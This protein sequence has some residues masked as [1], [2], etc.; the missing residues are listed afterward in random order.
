[1]FNKTLY[2]K[3]CLGKAVDLAVNEVR[4]TISAEKLE[5]RNWS[6]PVLYLGTRGGRV[7]EVAKQ[8]G[9]SIDQ[10]RN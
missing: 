6:T 9:D 10:G 3:L 5:E 7:L 8:Q 1:M 2:Q 4:E